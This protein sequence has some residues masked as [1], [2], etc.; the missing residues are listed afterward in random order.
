MAGVLLLVLKKNRKFSRTIIF[1]FRRFT[2]SSSAVTIM[3]MTCASSQ[4]SMIGNVEIEC[5]FDAK[6]HGR[7]LSIRSRC[8][9]KNLPQC[10][11]RGNVLVGSIQKWKK[12]R[13]E[14]FRHYNIEHFRT[15]ITEPPPHLWDLHYLYANETSILCGEKQ[16]DLNCWNSQT[17]A[18]TISATRLPNYVQYLT[19]APRKFDQNQKNS[20]S[21]FKVL[22]N[23][24]YAN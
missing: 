8:D 9:S 13:N 17:K 23:T 22:P 12:G 18:A 5:S 14:A 21:R 11:K 4:L 6:T 2:L 20:Q 24:K 7:N 10:S 19:I 16:V 1:R 3:L 15:K